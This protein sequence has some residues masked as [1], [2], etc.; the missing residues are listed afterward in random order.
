MAAASIGAGTVFLAK[1]YFRLPNRLRRR[2]KEEN[3][4]TNAMIGEFFLVF[5]FDLRNIDAYSQFPA[6]SRCNFCQSHK[7][8]QKFGLVMQFS[9]S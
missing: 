5:F 2:S 7:N 1:S 8:G 6:L 9:W 3:F 4:F